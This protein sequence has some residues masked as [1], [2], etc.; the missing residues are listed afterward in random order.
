MSPLRRIH[1][2]W[3]WFCASRTRESAA[4]LGLG[5]CGSE[6]DR[7]R[8]QGRRGR[9][10]D[11]PRGVGTDCGVR[12]WLC[13]APCETGVVTS[14]SG[15]GFPRDELRSLLRDFRAGWIRLWPAHTRNREAGTR[16][17]RNHSPTHIDRA[18]WFCYRTNCCSIA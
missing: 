14:C 5:V 4:A 2:R 15:A 17:P 1:G 13:S 11:S 12:I 7:R 8:P 3:R 10:L 9:H 6:P 18:G 16:T